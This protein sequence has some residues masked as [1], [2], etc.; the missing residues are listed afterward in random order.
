MPIEAM[1]VLHQAV[2]RVPVMRYA[3]GVVGIAAA[4]SIVTGLVGRSQA[5]LLLLALVFIGMVLLYIFSLAATSKPGPLRVAGVVLIWG[6]L[7]VFLTFLGFTVSAFAVGSPCPW[8]KLLAI[9]STCDPTATSLSTAAQLGCYDKSFAPSPAGTKHPK[10][11]GGTGWIFAGYVERRDD[12]FH[13]TQDGP[14]VA[15]PNGALP[16]SAPSEIKTSTAVVLRADRRVIMVDFGKVGDCNFLKTPISIP[17]GVLRP[18]DYT[19]VVLPKDTRV[20]VRD[21]AAG[22]FPKNDSWS[23]WLRVGYDELVSSGSN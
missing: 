17:G 8:A 13:W 10:L 15:Y 11:P 12:A 14:Y 20:I 9:K 23:I 21:V 2:K 1:S 6:V 4:G 7:L 18:E 22:H 5:T 3:L 19:G 16:S